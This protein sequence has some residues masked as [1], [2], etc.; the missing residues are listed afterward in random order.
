[1]SAALPM[2]AR[3]ARDEPSIE[4]RDNNEALSIG[5]RTMDRGRVQRTCV[6]CGREFMALASNVR[7]GNGKTCSRACQYKKNSGPGSP[8]FK[9][10]LCETTAKRTA[11]KLAYRRR[12]PERDRARNAVRRAIENGDLEREPCVRCGATENIHAHHSDYAQPLK[13]TWLCGECH[14]LR[15]WK[16]RREEVSYEPW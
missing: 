4:V 12:H 8:H 6:V 15:H 1:M 3:M 14:R 5:V 7:A 2:Q 16:L 13:V 10:G 9:H 11:Y